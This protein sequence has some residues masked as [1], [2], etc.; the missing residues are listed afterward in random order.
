M[1][2]IM[3]KKRKIEEH[4]NPDRWVISYADFITLLFA[5][6]T[7]MYAISHVDLGK[8]VRFSGS[9]K[10]AFKTSG[11]DTAETPVIEGIRPVNYADVRLEKDIRADLQNFDAL[12]G[13]SVERDQRGVIISFE[14]ALLFESG[15]ADLK[16]GSHPL[17]AV[18]ASAMRKSHRSIVVEGHTDNLPIHSS[19]YSSNLELSTARAA[20]VYAYLLNDETISPERMT[21][22]GYGE[23]RSVASNSTP[24]GRARNR[25]VD[26]LFVS[27]R[28]GT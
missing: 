23:Y 5:F 16:Q 12:E 17:L 9:M 26:I 18:I 22:S 8:L 14:D 28:D 2:V 15:T 4:D 10:S 27:N 11:S 24:E 6:F 7:T 13:I 25:R 20:N 1:G 19:R 3:R 21:A